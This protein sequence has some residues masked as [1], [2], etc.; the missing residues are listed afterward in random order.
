MGDPCYALYAVADPKLIIIQHSHAHVQAEATSGLV[1]EV[2]ARIHVLQCNIG[3]YPAR[4][5]QQRH[6]PTRDALDDQVNYNIA[7]RCLYMA[8]G[9]IVDNVLRK[10]NMV[11]STF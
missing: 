9:V 6:T 2:A 10:R 4:C 8:P 1:P 7:E 11:A 5:T 3:P